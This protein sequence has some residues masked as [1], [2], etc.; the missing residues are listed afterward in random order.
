MELIVNFL[1]TRHIPNYPLLTFKQTISLVRA[2]RP[3]GNFT[4]NIKLLS[5][6]RSA[7]KIW[8]QE[9]LDIQDRIYIPSYIC[10]DLTIPLTEMEQSITYYPCK[11]N[12]EPDWA[13][14]ENNIA[15]DGKALLL[16]HYFGFPNNI[17][18]A[19]KFANRHQIILLEDCAHS[20]LSRVQDKTIGTFGEAGFYS[21]HKL[22]PIPEGAGIYDNLTS[23]TALEKYFVQNKRMTSLEWPKRLLSILVHKLHIPSQGWSWLSSSYNQV[24]SPQKPK[25]P[26]QMSSLSKKIL[27]SY[28]RNFDRLIEVR[29]NNYELLAHELSHIEDCTVLFPD[30]HDGVCPHALPILV[31][32]ADKYISYLN[33][34]GVPAQKW[35]DLPEA[36]TKDSVCSISTDYASRLILLPIHQTLSMKSIYRIANVF[37]STNQFIKQL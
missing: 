5:N 33:Q 12:L 15:D 21:Y 11:A 1:L 27:Y 3:A 23:D 7:I 28:E 17:E 16:V 10:S 4:S 9:N 19:V 14:L 35:P 36:V 26:S 29:R 24:I 37:K 18:H 20:F 13:W 32:D 8:I 34:Q 25:S 2:Q 30:L 6:T 31:D 22:L